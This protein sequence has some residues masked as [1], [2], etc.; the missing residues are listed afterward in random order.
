MKNL[1]CL[2]PILL[3]VFVFACEKDNNTPLNQQQVDGATGNPFLD[4]FG[5]S[6]SARFMGNVINETGNPISGVQISIGNSIT[7]TDANGVFSIEEA[8]VYEKFAYIKASKSGFIDGSRSLVPSDGVNQVK[9]MMLDAE[10]LTTIYSGQEFNIGLPDGTSI[11]LPSTYE[12]Q[13]GFAYQGEVSVVLK[14]LNPDDDTMDLQMPGTLIAENESGDLRVLETYGMIA[15][16]LIASD[17]ESLNI[18]DGTEATI[19]IPVPANAVNPPSTIPLWYFDEVYGYWVE[20]GYATLEGDKYVGQ[21]THF[22]F[23]NCDDPFASSELC[24][25]LVTQNGDPLQNTYVQLQRESTDW[26][27]SSSGITNQNGSVCGLI[28]SDETLTLVLPD[29]GC[30]GYDYTQNIGPFSEDTTITVTV[31]DTNVMTTNLTGVFNNCSG[32]VATNGYVQL[33]YNNSSSIIPVT[34]GNLNLVIDYCD[35]DLGFSAQFFDLENGQSSD[36]VT[37]TFTDPLTD[38]GTEMS[39]TDL[40]DSDADGVLDFNEDLNGNNNLD[41]DDTDLDGIAD[42][43]DED[44]DNDGVNTIDEDYDNDGNP[45]NEDSDAD[46]IPDYLDP[47]DVVVFGTE[48][49]ANNCDSSNLQYD[50]TETYGATYPNTVF[51]YFETEADAETGANSIINPSYYN[52][53]NMLDVV[54]VVS[55]NTISNQSY[56]GQI[57]LLG[58]NTIDS[59]QDGLSDCEELTGVNNVNSNCDPNGNI[60]DPNAADSDGDGVDDCQE[61][62]NGTDPNDPLDF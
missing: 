16:E 56:I 20:E 61:A 1:R 50:L 51:T 33:F 43:L 3:L 55:T 12:Y 7:F 26:N 44:D 21:V 62:I 32:E 53:S 54:F 38:L 39:C 18:A 49:W 4:N 45:M 47:V 34:D 15:V 25:N 5:G 13:N 40:T 23:W 17:G 6:I 30:I 42:Y 27:S 48:I 10:P 41:D 59:D 24:V 8:T 35:T 37:G 29:F 19:T 28:P 14:H 11:D 22:S 60:T 46:Q 31:E 58:I 36:V 57:D 2:L 52:D 9:I